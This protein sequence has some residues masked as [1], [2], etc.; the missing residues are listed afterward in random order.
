MSETS[1][2]SKLA[3]C[4]KVL[5][6]G[7][8]GFLGRRLVEVLV[9][10]GFPV[11][12][13]VRKTS[14]LEG[15]QLAGV[16]IVYGDVTDLASLGPAF[17][18]V[19]YVVHAAAGT[20]GPEE[21][22]SRVTIDGTKNVVE[23]CR[24]SAVRKMVYISSCSVYGIAACRDGAV[25]DEAAP[26]EA[27]PLQ[28][29]AYSWTKL[30]AEKCVSANFDQRGLATVCL[31]AGTIYGPEGENFTPVVGF[32]LKNRIFLIINRKGFIMPLVYIDNFIDA[33]VLAMTSVE[34]SGKVYNV[35]DPEQVDKKRYINTFI[36]TLYPGSYCIYLPYRLLSAVVAM[37]E[38]LFGML[39]RKPILSS[40]RL[41]SSQTPVI[42]GSSKII[43]EL[44]WR[45][46]YSF[47]EAVAEITARED[48]SSSLRK[49]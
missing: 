48:S 41:A 5:V 22:M 20:S 13:L 25:L 10:R 31:R 29:G 35:V 23:A 3:N 34:S 42:Y 47:A 46:R 4:G 16:E 44:G 2:S 27:E 33:I 28:R 18:D 7:A 24:T 9:G 26:L 17:A 37:Q 40:Y 38:K 21:Q 45:Q 14:R 30:A 36:R 19:D 39:H 12:A 32:S 8:S 15:L 6:T 43:R 11:R 1:D 49:R